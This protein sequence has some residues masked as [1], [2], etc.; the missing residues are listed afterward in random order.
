MCNL[1]K[2]VLGTKKQLHMPSFLL[3]S[4]FV[5]GGLPQLLGGLGD[6]VSTSSV[7]VPRTGMGGGAPPSSGNRL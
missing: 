1:V 5:A 4:Y 2:W 3:I 7:S 6:G